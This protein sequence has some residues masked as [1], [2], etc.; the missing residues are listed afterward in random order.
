MR[1]K[2][3]YEPLTDAENVFSNILKLFLIKTLI[4]CGKR[5]LMTPLLLS[6]PHATQK[7]DE[8]MC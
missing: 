7:T 5:L 2:T 6:I 1:G 3:P 4:N 8:L